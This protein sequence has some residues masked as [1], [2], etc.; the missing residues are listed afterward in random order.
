MILN[1]AFVSLGGTDVSVYVKK[2]SV[3]PK[4]EGVNGAR[5]GHLSKVNEAG[6][7]EWNVAIT[8]KQSFTAA[9][10]DAILW[11]LFIAKAAF[12]VIVQPDGNTLG[13]N[14]PKFT[15]SNVMLEY[16]PI[17]TEHGKQV[18]ATTVF[19]CAGVMSRATA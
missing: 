16:T 10:I 11:A 5:M 7:Q 19:E 9:E 14:N 8:W 18:E 17:D 3:K 13:V 15:G 2:V 1:N 4:Y 6:L 12:T